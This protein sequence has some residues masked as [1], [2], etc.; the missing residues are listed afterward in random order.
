MNDHTSKPN[1]VIKQSLTF[2]FM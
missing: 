1:R 2:V